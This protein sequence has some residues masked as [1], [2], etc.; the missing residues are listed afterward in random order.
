MAPAGAVM[1]L[2]STK[3]KEKEEE[4]K[5]PMKS[6]RDATK[7][8]LTLLPMAMAGVFQK[9]TE[10]YYIEKITRFLSESTHDIPY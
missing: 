2:R 4:R 3:G 10:F 9:D 5:V 6:L 8:F 1:N 7:G